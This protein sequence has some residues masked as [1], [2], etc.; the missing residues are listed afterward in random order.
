MKKYVLI[1]AIF[2]FIGIIVA[3]SQQSNQSNLIFSH[4]FHAQE[5]EASCTDCHETVLE[6]NAAS[7]NLLPAMQTCY[8]CHDE[9]DTACTYCHVN[10]DQAREVNRI[11]SFKAKFPHSKH[12]ESD[13]DCLKCHEGISLDETAE[14]ALHIPSNQICS[15][16]H[17]TADYVEQQDLCLQ[18]HERDFRFKP[19]DHTKMWQKN[20]GLVSQIEA[21]SCKH[22]HQNNYCIQ[23][24]E[25]DNLNRLA[26]PLN[27]RNNHGIQAKG[28]KDNCLSCHQEF[29]FCI[30]CHKTEMVMPKNHSYANWSNT[31][32]G[33]RHAREALYDFDSC[34]SCHND[35][36]SDNICLRCHG[37]K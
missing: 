9:E 27:F 3:N 35:A 4:R 17:G 23:C 12:A 31:K 20:H 7:D 25:G 8:N 21:S 24:H 18:C 13:S 33:G 22:C 15:D 37:V 14:G 1:L 2:M 6:S 5:V 30:E 36:Y 26:H 29:A 19:E 10:P 32:E 28:N 34:L 16:C 11:V